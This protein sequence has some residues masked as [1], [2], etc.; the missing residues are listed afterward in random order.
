MPGIEVTCW[1]KLQN[2][3]PK[4]LV[5]CC[6]REEVLEKLGRGGVSRAKLWGNNFPI[7]DVMR[8]V[9]KQEDGGNLYLLKTYLSDSY[10]ED[11]MAVTMAF[12]AIVNYDEEAEPGAKFGM[13]TKQL[14]S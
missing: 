7:T 10:R 1:K 4:S 11:K 13:R 6:F 14:V 5:F 3:V 12:V 8:F 9:G 2:L